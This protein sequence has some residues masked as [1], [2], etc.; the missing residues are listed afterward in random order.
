MPVGSAPLR[1]KYQP[2]PVTDQNYGHD[3][4][5]EVNTD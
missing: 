1:E 3:T 5:S 4:V 2:T